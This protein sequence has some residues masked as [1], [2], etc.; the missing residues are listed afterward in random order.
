MSVIK[1]E[2][3]IPWSEPERSGK[4][5]KQTPTGFFMLHT[6]RKLFGAR[7]GVPFYSWAAPIRTIVIINNVLRPNG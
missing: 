5:R 7:S 3:E 4:T 2:G 6:L 1:W